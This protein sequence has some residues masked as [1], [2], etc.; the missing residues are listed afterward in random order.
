MRG[1]TRATHSPMP[2]SADRSAT[3]AASVSRLRD[4][5]TLRTAAC[6][7]SVSCLAR[8]AITRTRSSTGREASR[9]HTRA[10]SGLPAVTGAARCAWIPNTSGISSGRALAS[11]IFLTAPPRSGSWAGAR[12]GSS[13]TP[14][15][16]FSSSRSIAC[17]CCLP[18]RR[19]S[20]GASP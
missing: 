19:T 16:A 13:T 11:T 5:A 6:F 12:S 1:L 7:A 17:A 3:V 8:R 10:H 2:H 15:S 18:A 14:S 20:I 9:N 4:S